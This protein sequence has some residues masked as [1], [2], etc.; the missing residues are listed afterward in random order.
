MD[1][2][3]EGMSALMKL[4]VNAALQV[5]DVSPV[6]SAPF[7]LGDGTF[8][9]GA[10][11]NLYRFERDPGKVVWKTTYTGGNFA[12]V[13]A[14]QRPDVLYVGAEEVQR[15]IGGGG[16]SSIESW[17]T[18]FQAFQLSDGK[19]LWKRPMQFRN[20]RTREI[21]ALD[22]GLLVNDGSRSKGRL[23][24]LDYDTGQSLWGSKGRGVEVSGLVL[25]HA[26]T[27]A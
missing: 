1:A 18:G 12:F 7:E 2:L 6:Q 20:T 25:D 23:Y 4:V 8:V 11:G 19:P 9:L 13:Q 14:P 5:A 26:A 10:M 24:M 22:G 15:T 3:N 16:Q 27:D 17:T 21:V